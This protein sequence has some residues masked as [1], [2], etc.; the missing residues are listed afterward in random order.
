MSALIQR[1]RDIV[2]DVYVAKAAARAANPAGQTQ[3][4]WDYHVASYSSFLREGAYDDELS[5]QATLIA[6]QTIDAETLLRAA[7]D[8]ATQRK[9]A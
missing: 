2:A 1:A 9:S 7:I 6:L 4:E 5:V 3:E 8:L